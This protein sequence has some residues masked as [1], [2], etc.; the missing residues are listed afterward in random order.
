[1]FERFLITEA[2]RHKTEQTCKLLNMCKHS[3]VRNHRQQLQCSRSK[4]NTHCE[5]IWVGFT[6]MACCLWGFGRT[7]V[8][9]QSIQE[10]AETQDRNQDLSACAT[11]ASI[12]CSHTFLRE[13]DYTSLL[14]LQP[15]INREK[16]LSHK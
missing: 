6:Q 9:Q 13:L 15:S 10:R 8:N 11:Y 14:I 2:P 1:M 5:C 7:F 3:L 16:N 12:P 4:V